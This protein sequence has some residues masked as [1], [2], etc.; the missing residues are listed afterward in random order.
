MV[1]KYLSLFSA[2]ESCDDHPLSHNLEQVLP[3][4]FVP[5][6]NLKVRLWL[7]AVP[8]ITKATIP[9]ISRLGGTRTILQHF[10][11]PLPTAPF[12]RM[13]LCGTDIFHKLLK[14]LFLMLEKC[15][16]TFLRQLKILGVQELAFFCAEENWSGVSKFHQCYSKQS[17]VKQV[18]ASL[19]SCLATVIGVIRI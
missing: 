19:K 5:G 6:A 10:S 18:I 2:S 7:I 16:N 8:V 1:F 9:F 14:G 4:S 13:V 3:A 17:S 12:L 11:K 15:Y